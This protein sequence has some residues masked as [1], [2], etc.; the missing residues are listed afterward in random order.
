MGLFDWLFGKKKKDPYGGS[1]RQD[2][3]S[4]R[5]Y[6]DQPVERYQSKATRRPPA[7]ESPRQKHRTGKLSFRRLRSNQALDPLPDQTLDGRNPNTG[8]LTGSPLSHLGG[9]R[10]APD[11]HTDAQRLRN[12]GLPVVEHLDDLAELLGTARDELVYLSARP[13]VEEPTHYTLKE[14]PKKSGGTRLLMVPMPRL[15]S[16]QRTLNAK[17]ISLLPVHD[18]VHGFRTGRDVLS[19]AS[20]HVSK[21]VLVSMDIEDFF[22]SFTFR[23]VAGYFRSLGYGRGTCVALAN[24]TTFRLADASVKRSN[25]NAWKLASVHHH[26]DAMRRW[27]P[28]LPQGAPTSPGIANAIARR[29][30]KRLHALALKFG[31][32]YTRYADD[33]TFSGGE[34][35]AK[36]VGRLLM[37]ARKIVKTEGLALNEN[38]TRI[39]RK[40]RQ[41]RVTGVV[42]NQQTN[43]SRR[44]FDKLKAILHN[45]IK[46]GPGG[47][48]R[49]SVPD[50]KEHLRGRIAHISHIGPE[51]GRKLKAMFDQIRW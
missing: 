25:R 1:F 20:A 4:G 13:T 14:L 18:C 21:D 22:P 36:G 16:L 7:V 3:D 47:Q 41:Q 19:S 17:L 26:P 34:E 46:H 11:P 43:V 33:L 50:F 42:V 9:T 8:Q 49:E 23:R 28:E 24:L 31:A 27:H 39:M 38:K 48:N 40:G 10:Q 51:R 2:Y 6:N 30:D 15:K 12:H 37:L 44:D 5:S 35:L 45:C 29:M 32:D